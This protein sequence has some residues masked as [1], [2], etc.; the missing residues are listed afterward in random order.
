MQ[1]KPAP[2]QPPASFE[3]AMTELEQLVARME[4]GELPLEASVAAYQRGSELV[5]Y[6]AAQLD[7]VDS[8]VK[9]LEGELM[10]PLAAA[11][12]SAVEADE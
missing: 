11:S 7:K 10:K 3:Q 12:D 2:G 1:K 6:C 5:K 9:I 4:A 8:Q